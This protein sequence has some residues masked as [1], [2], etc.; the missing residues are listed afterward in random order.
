MKIVECRERRI[1][2]TGIIDPYYINEFTI[3]YHWK[4]IEDNL[5][6]WLVKQNTCAEI[7]FPYVFK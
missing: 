6:R 1:Y 7:L 3:K 2:D 4:D 5:L